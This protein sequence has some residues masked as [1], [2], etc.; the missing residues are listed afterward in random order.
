MAVAWTLSR[1]AERL[2]VTLGLDDEAARIVGASIGGVGVLC[3]DP[4]GLAAIG[5]A[6]AKKLSEDGD[7]AAHVA[8]IGFDAF[9]LAS[10]V[11]KALAALPSTPDTPEIRQCECRDRYC[12]LCNRVPFVLPGSPEEA[13]CIA[14][15]RARHY[16]TDEG[17][18]YT[19]D[20][21]AM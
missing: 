10:A 16:E 17:G 12:L 18:S 3:G 5:Q 20:P 11:S 7:L 15:Y 8:D 13:E 2:L 6:V 19:V 4:S 14:T 9:S 1:A 21:W